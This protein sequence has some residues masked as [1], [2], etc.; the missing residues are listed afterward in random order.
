MDLFQN[1]TN[2]FTYVSVYQL[3]F[4]FAGVAWTQ[5]MVLLELVTTVF[6][7]SFCAAFKTKIYL[8]SF[9]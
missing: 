5:H 9:T 7:L 8:T 1:L 2:W 4:S 3:N 6:F